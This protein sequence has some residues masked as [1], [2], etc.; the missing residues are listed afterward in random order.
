VAIT[1][2]GTGSGKVSIQA[3]LSCT[4]TFTTNASRHL[5]VAGSYET[6]SGTAP[7]VTDS[8][9]GSW[10]EKRKVA[11]NGAGAGIEVATVIYSENRAAI[12]SVT[13]TWGN[14]TYANFALDQWA[15]V[16][17]S[18]SFDSQQSADGV[19]STNAWGSDNLTNTDQNCLIYGAAVANDSA[20]LPWTAPGG[21]WTEIFN[22]PDTTTKLA[23]EAIFQIA[24]GSTGPFSATFTYTGM[25][26]GSYAGAST[27]VS[28]KPLLQAPVPTYANTPRDDELIA[29]GSI[30]GPYS[31]VKPQSW[32]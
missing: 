17:T 24:S 6:A 3:A 20:N 7:T 27:L 28:F 4:I 18:G 10:A 5:V 22:E 23:S 29:L 19:A 31:W 16:I 21:S 26:S 8:A 13:L 15:G 11:S 1:R 9:S 12:T 32:F 2:D 25:S 14:T 30:V